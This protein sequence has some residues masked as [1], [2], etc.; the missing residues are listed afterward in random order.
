MPFKEGA[1]AF[2][3]SVLPGGVADGAVGVF[4]N[5]RYSWR[6]SECGVREEVEL[7]NEC[8]E[9]W[10]ECTGVAYWSPDAGAEAG[11]SPCDKRSESE[12]LG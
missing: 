5:F 3:R 2:R 1:A 10:A 11:A 6:E 7:R 9:L 8:C 12:V 4:C